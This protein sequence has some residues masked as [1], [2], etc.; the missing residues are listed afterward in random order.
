MI[1]SLVSSPRARK[2]RETGRT[3]SL[4][5]AIGAYVYPHAA[6]PT[7]QVRPVGRQGHLVRNRD[8]VRRSCEYAVSSARRGIPWPD[9]E[10]THPMTATKIQT[11]VSIDTADLAAS[12]AFYRTLLESEPAVQRH[13]YARFDISDPPLVLGLNAVRSLAAPAHS[14]LEHLGL[15]LPDKADLDAA[16]QRLLGACQALEEEADTECCYA[17]LSRLWATDPSGIRWEIFV[18]HEEV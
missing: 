5:P 8:W 16:R 14:P 4:V 7:S 1:L 11:H 15:R 6:M 17:R 2:R 3:S 10:G 12:V 18:A 9:T 13:D